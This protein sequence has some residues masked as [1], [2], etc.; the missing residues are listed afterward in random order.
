[1]GDC[2][3]VAMPDTNSIRI[4]YV[5]C[6]R[7]YSETCAI[8][9]TQTLHFALCTLH[10]ICYPFVITY[11]NIGR[12]LHHDYTMHIKAMNI[13]N[14]PLHI[15]S[16]AVLFLAAAGCIGTDFLDESAELFEPR[17]VV[18][19]AL[20]AIEVNQTV[21]YEATYYDSTDTPRPTTFSWSS[22]DEAIVSI[23]EDGSAMGLQSGQA[24][25]TAQA[26]GIASEV[27]L[28]TVVADANAVAIVRISPADTSITEGDFLQYTA[29]AENA[30]GG[31]IDNV[32]F[33][34]STSIDSVAT[35][36]DQGLL[37]GLTT[38]EVEVTASTAGIISS[39]AL[40]NVF[41]T[42]R[43][44]IFQKTPGTSYNLAGGVE[45][46]QTPAGGLQ[47][48]FLDT[49]STSNGPDLHVYLSSDS[50]VNGRS[51]DLGELKSTS[52]EQTYAVPNSVEMNDFD[53]VLIHCL[54]FNVTFGFARLN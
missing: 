39:P 40:L 27:A 1:M 21:T 41:A 20:E 28:L 50:R 35:I 46:E 34:W 33:T 52:G 4:C 44:G 38:G 16:S 6:L 3:E 17:I 5:S 22:S 36:N 15:L 26:F 48:R 18:T 7:L 9:C 43:S 8:I 19:P 13:K 25:I 49:F 14:F 23:S 45:L 2:V 32:T 53:Y 42:S 29:Q 51:L 11:F 37:R 24:E 12:N 30:D 10:L 31:V 47:L 54:P